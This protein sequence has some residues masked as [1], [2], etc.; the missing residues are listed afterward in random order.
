MDRER[1]V[2]LVIQTV[3]DQDKQDALIILF[4]EEHGLTVG[5]IEFEVV[6]ILREVL[7]QQWGDSGKGFRFLGKRHVDVPLLLC[8]CSMKGQAQL[9]IR[10]FLEGGACGKQDRSCCHVCMQMLDRLMA[11][12]RS[13]VLQDVL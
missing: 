5:L 9:C 11:R 10:I 13:S 7:R 6:P 1:V 12:C 8:A 4:F 3:E 2:E